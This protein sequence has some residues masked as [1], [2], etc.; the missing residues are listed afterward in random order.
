MVDFSSNRMSGLIPSVFFELPSLQQLTLSFNEFTKV[1]A[2]Y[3]G[4]ESRSRLIAV[5]LSNN[6]LEGFLPSFMAMMPKLSSLSLE[7]NE[8]TGRIATQLAEKTVSPK[9][10]VTP[11]ERLLLRGNYLVGGIPRPLL[12]LKRDSANVSLVDN[13]LYRCPHTFFFCQGGQQKSL[14]QCNR[15]VSTTE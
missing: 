8:F 10:G 5:D 14:A 7:N 12:T 9:T 15:F 13:C 3:K 11:L 6:R 4:V 1:E 2:P